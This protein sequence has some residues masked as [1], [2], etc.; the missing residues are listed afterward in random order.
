[1]IMSFLQ[2]LLL[3]VCVCQG[4]VCSHPQLLRE[5]RLFTFD[6]CASRKDETTVGVL[7]GESSSDFSHTPKTLISLCFIE[8]FY[9][10]IALVCSALQPECIFTHHPPAYDAQA[11]PGR[12]SLMIR[13]CPPFRRLIEVKIRRKR[14]YIN[15]MELLSS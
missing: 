9:H 2:S 10:E 1:M 13:K 7:C 12:Y 6:F 8:F 3:L 15:V 5:G 14:L 4:G 11:H